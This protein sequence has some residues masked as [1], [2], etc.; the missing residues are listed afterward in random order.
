MHLIHVRNVVAHQRSAAVFTTTRRYCTHFKTAVQNSS[1]KSPLQ[2]CTKL[3]W[4]VW[5]GVCLTKQSKRK[6]NARSMA[7]ISSLYKA[8]WQ[9]DKH[10]AE[11]YTIFQPRIKSLTSTII[12]DTYD[13]IYLHLFWSYVSAWQSQSQKY[14]ICMC[15]KALLI[16]R[17]IHVL[18]W[19]ALFLS[20]YTRSVRATK[21]VKQRL[22]TELSYL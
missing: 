12:C 6:E 20:M 11:R 4:W 5:S 1:Y 15:F 13:V 3:H 8:Y 16:K 10:C 18:F 21:P 17:F 9:K 22:I 7:F 2:E 14:I 19:R